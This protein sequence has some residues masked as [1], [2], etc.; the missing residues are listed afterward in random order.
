MARLLRLT[1]ALAALFAAYLLWAWSHSLHP[2][3]A[4]YSVKPGTGIGALAAE[5]HRRGVLLESRSFVLLGYLT[6]Q[7]SDAKAGEYRFREGMSQREILQQVAAGHVL[8]YPLRIVE[9]LN[10]RQV[11]AELAT[12]PSLSHTLQGMT[13]AQIMTRLGAPGVHPEGRFYPDTYF[14]AGGNTDFAILRRAYEKMEARLQ[15]EWEN[16]DEDLPYKSADEALTMA[17]IVEKETGRADERRLIAGVFVN[18]LKKHMRLGT[19]PTVIYGL[20]EKFDGDLRKRD[21]LTDTP[22]NTYTRH[23]LPPTPIAMPGGDSIYAALHPEKTGALYFVSR[24]DGAHVFSDTLE[25]HNR[26]VSKYQLGGRPF[27]PTPGGNDVPPKP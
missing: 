23:G 17:S 22:Y 14:Y 4:T 8:E 20:G 24:G 21:L 26:A 2:G 10:F 25:E 5:L 11:L 6:A 18:R 12:A 15:Q 19:D 1:F 9:G 27:P 7:K 3:Q 16:R 13:Y